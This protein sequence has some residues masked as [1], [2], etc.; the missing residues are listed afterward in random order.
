MQKHEQK[1]NVIDEQKQAEKKHEETANTV[2]TQTSHE[3]SQHMARA[4]L[5]MGE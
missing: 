5:G 4:V 1:N 3:D 2:V